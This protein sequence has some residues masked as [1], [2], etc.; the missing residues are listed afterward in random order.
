MNTLDVDCAGAGHPYPFYYNAE[1]QTMSRL[2]K[3]GT[4]L[5]WVRDIEYPKDTVTLNPGDK[6]FLFTDGISELRNPDGEMFGEQRIETVM[7][8]AIKNQEPFLTDY[9]IGCLSDYT[10]GAPLEDD[11]SMMLIEAL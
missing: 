9:L 8:E 10:E 7:L 1:K 5:V 3:N 2:Q 11:I 4:P 6:I